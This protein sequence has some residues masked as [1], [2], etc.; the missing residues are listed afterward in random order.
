MFG[1]SSGR[2]TTL[3]AAAV[4]SIVGGISIARADFT[5]VNPSF[6]ASKPTHQQVIEHIYG[7]TFT[8]VGGI[9]FTNGV[10]TATRVDDFFSGKPAPTPNSIVGGTPG[11]EDQLWT[12]G[13]V[14]VRALAHFASF[15]TE[16]GYF[17]GGGSTFT[18][19]FTIPKGVFGYISGP[20]TTVDLTGKTW[21]WGRKATADNAGLPISVESSS[22]QSANPGAQDYFVTYKITGL[23]D[24]LSTWLVFN[25]DTNLARDYDFNDLTV[26]V[27][28][29]P[30]SPAVWSGFGMLAVAWMGR[31]VR[32]LMQSA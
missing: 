18:S 10:I 16:F 8:V 24:G 28:A 13:K 15:G 29:V 5:P 30:V 27:K 26:E 25:E 21:A 7:G 9:N 1:R 32:K 31:G 19:L 3:V 4:L 11:A 22:L 6:P 20:S 23:Q 12:N 14:T 17:E 2:L